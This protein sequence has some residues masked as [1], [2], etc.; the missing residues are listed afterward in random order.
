MGGFYNPPPFMIKIFSVS[1]DSP[2]Q[3][4]MRN[5]KIDEKYKEIPIILIISLKF[6]RYQY[7]IFN[8]N[9]INNQLVILKIY[10]F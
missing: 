1:H 8:L 10:I 2:S 5:K 7:F 4:L 3:V 9:H 6:A